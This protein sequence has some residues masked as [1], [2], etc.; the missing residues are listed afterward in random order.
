MFIFVRF[1]FMETIFRILYTP[2]RPEVT[3]SLAEIVRDLEL[4]AGLRYWCL[5]IWVLRPHTPE[6]NWLLAIHH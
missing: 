1:C 3:T 6:E 5:S 4:E 2:R